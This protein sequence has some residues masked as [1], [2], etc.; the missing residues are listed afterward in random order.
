MVEKALPRTKCASLFS[1]SVIANQKKKNRRERK[2]RKRERE[3][4]REDE[5]GGR[6]GCGV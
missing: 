1:E 4:E 3:R 5:E 2:Q 6:E